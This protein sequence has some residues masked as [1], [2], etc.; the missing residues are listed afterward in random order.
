MALLV[1]DFNYL[2]GQDGEIVV[3]ELA[4]VNS[5]SNRVSSYMF[6]SPY[7]WKDVPQFIARMN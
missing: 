2:D 3:K 1:I 4:V 6:K 7:A 5:H